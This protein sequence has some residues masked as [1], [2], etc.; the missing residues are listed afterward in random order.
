MYIIYKY[1]FYKYSIT[2]F[3]FSYFNLKIIQN[4]TQQ[5]DD[6]TL[7]KII[8][9]VIAFTTTEEMHNLSKYNNTIYRKRAIDKFPEFSTTHPGLFNTIIDNPKKFDMN[10]LRQMLNMRKKINNNDITFEE[11]S[12]KIGQQ[13]Y[14]EF[15]KPLVDKLP[16][17]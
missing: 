12:T 15:A 17:N 6:N 1:I 9:S 13:Y 7:L 16:K 10:R 3:I 2:S 14:D 5:L 11:A 8:E 4:M